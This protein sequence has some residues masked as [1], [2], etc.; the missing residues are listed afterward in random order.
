MGT[1]PGAGCSW[2]CA[3]AAEILASQVSGSVCVVDCDLHTPTLQHE[4]Q[5]G[6]HCGLADALVGNGSVRQYVQQLSRPNLWLLGSGALSEDASFQ[7]N[8][9]RMHQRLS[10]LR[11]EF[12]YILVDS[13]PRSVNGDGL[14]LGAWSDG[15]VLVLKAN[16]SHREAARSALQ[17]LQAANVSVLG[18]VLNQRT[19]PI[20]KKI[21]SWL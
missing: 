14:V 8:P 9:E 19:F 18:A 3:H 21:Y 13:T 5:V 4:F 2:I 15:I 20:P 11:A 12:D 7:A 17:E 6:T 1:E 10:E 16:S